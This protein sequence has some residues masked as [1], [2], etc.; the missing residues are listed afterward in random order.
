[1]PPSLFLYDWFETKSKSIFFDKPKP[2]FGQHLLIDVRPCFSI[3]GPFYFDNRYFLKS[4]KF[5]V[6]GTLCFFPF[7]NS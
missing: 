4:S 6:I 7:I 1:M 3:C 5:L 2:H